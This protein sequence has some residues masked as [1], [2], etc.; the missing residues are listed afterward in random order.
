MLPDYLR[1]VK[2]LVTKYSSVAQWKRA[3]LITQR[4]VDRNYSLLPSFFFLPLALRLTNRIGKTEKLSFSPRSK[5]NIC[6][7]FFMQLLR[8]YRQ[9]CNWFFYTNQWHDKLI[10]I[11]M[12]MISSWLK[13]KVSIY[14]CLN[15]KTKINSNY[16]L[17]E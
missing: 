16:I 8:N 13:T 5:N 17:N 1:S 3:G 11:M 9:T 10:R 12:M 15:K 2:Y 4:S 6:F 14:F 7:N